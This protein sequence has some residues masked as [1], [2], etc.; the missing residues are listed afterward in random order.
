M[1]H[2]IWIILTL[3]LTYTS[4]AQTQEKAPFGGK[5]IEGYKFAIVVFERP[6]GSEITRFP[7]GKWYLTK[8]S[9]ASVRLP[10][11]GWVC[12]QKPMTIIYT[13]ADGRDYSS[14]DGYHW[15]R[16]H[17]KEQSMQNPSNVQKDVLKKNVLL[18]ENLLTV[19]PK[20]QQFGLYRIKITDLQGIVVVLDEKQMTPE[21]GKVMVSIA[22]LSSGTYIYHISNGI[23]NFTGL[24]IKF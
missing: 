6:D 12:K 8:E 22:N 3:L 9:R 2:I 13:T 24:F 11:P 15:I 1:K 23:T 21:W 10:I 14:F 17:N 7:N 5:L 16:D 19:E 18:V 20:I 4:N